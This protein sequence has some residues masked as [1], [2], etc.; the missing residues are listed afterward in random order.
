MPI[1]PP[2]DLLR[3]PLGGLI[4]LLLNLGLGIWAHPRERV[5]AR[6]LWVGSALVQAILLIAV[7]RLVQ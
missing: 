1:G 4:V 2:S 3:L 5:V 7:V 6:M